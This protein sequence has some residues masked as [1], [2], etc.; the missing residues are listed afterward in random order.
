MLYK[1]NTKQY[2]LYSSPLPHKLKYLN[3]PPVMS[4]EHRDHPCSNPEY[5]M[6]PDDITGGQFSHFHILARIFF[7]VQSHTT[8]S[9]KVSYVLNRATSQSRIFCLFALLAFNHSGQFS[10]FD[11]FAKMSHDRGNLHG[12]PLMLFCSPNTFQRNRLFIRFL[13]SV[14]LFVRLL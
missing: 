4:S 8:I 12:R 7:S 14:G 2:I 5:S 6:C 1:Y 10:F 3:C 11:V 9:Y 13:F